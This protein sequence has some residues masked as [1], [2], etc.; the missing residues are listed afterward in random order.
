MKDHNLKLFALTP[1]LVALFITQLASERYFRIWRQWLF[2]ADIDA[3]ANLT[4]E[5]ESTN[6]E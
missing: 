3:G 5:R 4:P 1:L 2:Q 6:D